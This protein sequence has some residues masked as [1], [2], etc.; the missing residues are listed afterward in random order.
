MS[1]SPV[2][3]HQA[4]SSNGPDRGTDSS[5]P[6]AKKLVTSVWLFSEIFKH[7][8][9]STFCSYEVIYQK[10]LLHTL[11]KAENICA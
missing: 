11:E 5:P 8:I 10:V 9:V 6:P 1:E 3:D 2:C 7:R 4:P